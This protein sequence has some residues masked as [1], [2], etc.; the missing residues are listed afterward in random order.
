VDAHPAGNNHRSFDEATS[1]VLALDLEFYAGLDV[2]ID[3]VAEASPLPAL[4]PVQ[5]S[6][7]LIGREG[8]ASLDVHTLAQPPLQLQDPTAIVMVSVSGLHISVSGLHIIV[9]GLHIIVEV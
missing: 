5:P 1:K 6:A 2:L 3:P 8:Q 4:V 7:V 9:S